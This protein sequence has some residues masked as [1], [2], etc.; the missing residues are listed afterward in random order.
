MLVSEVIERCYN[1]YLYPAGVDRPPFDVLTADLSSSPADLSL[2]L[3]GRIQNIPRDVILEIGSELLLGKTVGNPYTVAL[4]GYLETD[5]AEH[6]IGDLVY[7]DPQYPRKQITNALNGILRGLYPRI[8]ARAV[9]TAQTFSRS[10]VKTLPTG[11]KD[12]L[13][14]TITDSGAD[15]T[16][17]RLKQA[18]RDW[19]TYREFDPAKYQL[20]RGG[21]EGNALRVIYTKDFTSSTLETDDLETVCG[22]PP[23]LQEHLPMGIT[24]RLLMGKELSRI[25]I[26]EIRRLL[27]AEGVQP[28]ASVNV[29]Q[30]LTNTFNT[31]HVGAEQ[32]RLR[33]LDPMTFEWIRS[34]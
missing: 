5:V 29:S 22:V 18:G 33:D 32:R 1:E 25:H 24:G 23:S 12:V 6:V 8:Y 17:T 9:D 15:E 16:Y 31:I 11:G 20:L 19:E 26:E 2:T 3:E 4:R 14:I 10:G 27:A 7:V 13:R 30:V 34:T 21:G 28:G